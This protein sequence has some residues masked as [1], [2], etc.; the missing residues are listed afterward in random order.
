MY[1][2]ATIFYY[3]FYLLQALSSTEVENWI[4]AIHSACASSLARQHGK[5]NTLKLI[6]SEQH[7]L[8]NNID[9]VR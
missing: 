5:D 6:K 3:F 7:K 9:V 1:I 2:E 4:C 8:E